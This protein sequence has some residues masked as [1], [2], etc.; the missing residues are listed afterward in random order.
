MKRSG[1]KTIAGQDW[2]RESYQPSC[3]SFP[4]KVHSRG[5]HSRV[6][7]PKQKICISRA[8]ILPSTTTGP[9]SKDCELTKLRP[10]L[11]VTLTAAIQHRRRNIP[12]PTKLMQNCWLN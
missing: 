8:L 5:S 4:R 3:D 10:F 1:E 11:T 7:R 6:R 9:C 2:A 12:S